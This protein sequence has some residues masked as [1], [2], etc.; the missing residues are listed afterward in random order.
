MSEKPHHLNAHSPAGHPQ[1]ITDAD[2]ARS[3]DMHSRTVKYTISMSVRLA[4]FIAAFF[5]HGWLQVVMLVLAVILPY[6][7]VIVA[8]ASGADLD[9]RTTSNYYDGGAPAAL[10]EG[11]P[12]GTASGGTGPDGSGTAGNTEP[13]GA[14]GRPASAAPGTG[15]D[16]GQDAE[17]GTGQRSGQRAAAP[18]DAEP[19]S[20]EPAS[21]DPTPAD[22]LPGEWYEPQ[23]EPGEPGQRAQDH[24]EQ[25]APGQHAFGQEAP[26]RRHHDPAGHRRKDRHH[27]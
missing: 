6:F 5:V 14:P 7:A 21:A 18:E 15:P 10:P 11:A 3:A 26:G 8:N 12:G 20:A 27:G 16:S 9:K 2:E 1:R 13:A 19:A 24:P 23:D 25:E 17:R 22:V 4:C